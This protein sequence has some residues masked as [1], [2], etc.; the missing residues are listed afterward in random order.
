MSETSSINSSSVASSQRVLQL[1][2]R[3]EWIA[4]EQ[5]IKGL[6]KGDSQISQ[7][8]EVSIWSFFIPFMH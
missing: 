1:A 2:L 7:F 4:L 5:A 3:G 6:D 8:D